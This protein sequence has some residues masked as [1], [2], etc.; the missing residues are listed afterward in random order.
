MKPGLGAAA[1]GPRDIEDA[2][3]E[4]LRWMG[5]V[6]LWADGRLESEIRAGYAAAAAAMRAAIDRLNQKCMEQGDPAL[7]GGI[8]HLEALNALLGLDEID[9]TLGVDPVMAEMRMRIAIDAA[10][11]EPFEDGA[12]LEVRA[13]VVI[14]DR[15]ADYSMPLEIELSST[16]AA[17][18]RTTGTTDEIGYFTTEVTL[19]PGHDEAVIETRATHPLTAQLFATHTATSRAEYALSLHVYGEKSVELEA[20]DVAGLQ[21]TL[22]KAGEPLPDATVSLA[23]LGGGSVEPPTVTTDG[24]G[25]GA[26]VYT[27]PD[28][29]DTVRIIARFSEGSREVADTVT[30]DVESAG[31]G[32]VE[33]DQLRQTW[34][35]IAYAYAGSK[36]SV[37]FK[38]DSNYSVGSLAGTYSPAVEVFDDG[39]G[40]AAAGTV[41]HSSE[42]VHGDTLTLLVVSVSGSADGEAEVNGGP[43]GR[44]GGKSWV[45]IRFEVLHAPVYDEIIAQGQANGDASVCFELFPLDGEETKRVIIGGPLTEE[46]CPVIADGWLEPGRYTFETQAWVLVGAGGAHVRGWAPSATDSVAYDVVFKIHDARPK[47]GR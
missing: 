7:V 36:D 20:G 26:A 30:L 8:L 18:A 17:L 35:A 46:E 6:Q 44:F 16:T 42:I 21:V 12:T 9:P 22:K 39:G 33:L 10:L 5:A 14:G 4:W 15:P 45:W 37:D 19:E 1:A 28:S 31:R 25:I 40:A 3:A 34:D 47:A 32:K 43:V 38:N 24:D 27:A 23:V 13:G 41:T 29:S 2:I 11:P